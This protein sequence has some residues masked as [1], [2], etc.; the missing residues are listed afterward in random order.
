MVKLVGR[1][2]ILKNGILMLLEE[3]KEPVRPLEIRRQLERRLVK[4]IHPEA[5]A[6]ALK[7]LCEE[8]QIAKKLVHGKIVY[9]VSN[10]YHKQA[11]RNLL[12]R[13]VESFGLEELEANFTWDKQRLP[14]VVYISPSP[15]DPYETADQSDLRMSVDVDWKTPSGGISSIICNDYLLLPP[16]VREGL[17]NLILWCYWVA[18]Q[19]EKRSHEIHGV[20][21]DSMEDRLKE[22]LKFAS[23]ILKKAKE[24]GDDRRIQTEE[25]IIRILNITLELLKKENLAD[26]LGYADA[27]IDHVKKEEATVLSTQGHFVAGG[28]RIFHNLV[29]EK[30]DM[31]FYG[32]SSVEERVGKLS[33]LKSIFKEPELSFDAA[34]WNDFVH[35]L[36][37]LSPPTSINDVKGSFEEAMERAKAYLQYLNDLIRLAR[38]RQI[39]VIYLWNVPVKKESEKYLKLPMF[40]EWLKALKMGELSHRVWLFEE[41]TFKKVESAYR[42][43]KRGRRPEPLKIDK[44]FWTLRDLYELH[45]KGKN[46]EFWYDIITALKTHKGEDP[47]RG[48]PVPKEFYYK[49]IERQREA[50][51]EFIERRE[52]E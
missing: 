2:P 50:V 7:A 36:I 28:E 3:A 24:D 27:N 31:V 29:I 39:A 30:N 34:V 45:P 19:Q 8:D 48:G 43:V 52:D 10:Q 4:K 49:M 35:F 25:A 33:G 37:E 38:R 22:C 42:A 44:E 5:V 40:E 21:L 41:N 15:N 6:A 23:S 51:K 46:P 1:T 20:K 32:L 16:A 17:A 14:N 26:F 18:I 12:A 47:Y 11:V 13:I 9:E